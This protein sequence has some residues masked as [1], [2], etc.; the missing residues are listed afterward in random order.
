MTHPPGQCMRKWTNL[1][2]IEGNQCHAS[3]PHLVQNPFSKNWIE[4]MF[5]LGWDVF[6]S[7]MLQILEEL[8][9]MW[10][11]LLLDVA[12][13]TTHYTGKVS[14]FTTLSVTDS[15]STTRI[16]PQMYGSIWKSLH[17]CRNHSSAGPRHPAV[18]THTHVRARLRAQTQE[19]LLVWFCG[20]VQ[21]PGGVWT[22]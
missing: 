3:T 20:N 21:I 1:V 14:S 17:I 19:R 7:Q 22:C 5:W 6:F 10:S 18:H 2:S 4:Y 8:N 12:A 9:N 13:N 15:A 16:T 11:M